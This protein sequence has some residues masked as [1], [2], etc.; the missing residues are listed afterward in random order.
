MDKQKI[1]IL[2]R[3]DAGEVTVFP[4]SSEAAA[5]MKA[6]EWANVIMPEKLTYEQSR[7]FGTITDALANVGYNDLEF[8]YQEGVIE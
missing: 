6:I 3:V 1:G 2:I 5:L 8:L 7:N 4:F